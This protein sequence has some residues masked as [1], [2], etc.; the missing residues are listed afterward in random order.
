[1]ATINYKCDTCKREIEL[2]ENKLGLT[3]FSTCTITKDCR[4]S[5]ISTKRNPYNVR[6]NI[7]K[8]DKALDDYSERKMFYEH[9]QEIPS[10]TWFVEHGLGDSCIFIV[11]D[12]NNLVMDKSNYTVTRQA[13]GI[14]LVSF[15]S[16]II[17]TVHVLSRTGGAI[18]DP[19]T[20]EDAFDFQVSFND[21]ITF[22]IPKFISRVDSRAAP[23]EPPDDIPVTPPVSATPLPSPA[24]SDT[25][26]PLYSLSDKTI[27]IEIEVIK[28]NEPSVTCTE[29]L[30][31]FV[32]ST[33]AWFGWSE[34]LVRNRKHYCVRT[35]KISEL[36]VFTNTNSQKLNIPNGTIL[37][38]KRIKYGDASNNVF[39]NIPDRGLLMLFSE[40]PH[41]SSDKIVD[42]LL[43]CGE[44]VGIADQ[45]FRFTDLDLYVS[46]DMIEKSYPKISKYA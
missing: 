4:G 22:A 15:S 17:G 36:K 27:Q 18:Y 33:S 38:I 28:P 23:I 21:V 41:T 19:S 25:S 20:S 29:T 10:A 34:I 11:F 16:K 9:I 8:H 1:M 13:A 32:S 40:S 37:K 35:I 5:L 43:D 44:M 39:V 45:V 3:T 14:S 24:P 30:D 46:S 7:P 6:E 31:A 42:K 2:L 26:Y 12:E